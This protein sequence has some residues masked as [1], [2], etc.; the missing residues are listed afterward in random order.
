MKISVVIPCFN[1]EKYISR[2][3]NSLF[4]QSIGLEHLQIILVDD[5]STDN[6]HAILRAYEQQYPEQ[7]LLVFS[8]KNGRQG[9]ARN[10]GLTYAVGDYISFVDADDWIRKDMYQILVNI[11]EQ[12]GSDL[13]QFQYTGRME[14]CPDE[15]LSEEQLQYRVYDIADCDARRQLL[16]NTDVMNQSCTCK[17]YRRRLFL[18]AGVSYAEGVSYEEPLF[19]YPLKFY[20]NRIAVLPAA[21]YYYRYNEAGTTA[22]YM[23]RP[24]TILEHLSVQLQTFDFMRATPFFATYRREIELYFLHSYFV[25]PF[26]FFH[27]RGFSLTAK[28]FRHMCDTVKA[29]VPDYLHNPYLQAETLQ[30]E[31]RIIRLID[32]LQGKSD[33]EIEDSLRKAMNSL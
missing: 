29:M 5:C 32:D 20:V 6:T 8:E 10:I 21:L 3:L 24:S 12:T 30:T 25:E 23:S 2:C 16:L 26:Y 28:L 4:E 17:F 11:M 1:V 31:C 13:V 9:A 22:T 18:D 33:K 14:Y 15:L 19:T 7:I 27:Y